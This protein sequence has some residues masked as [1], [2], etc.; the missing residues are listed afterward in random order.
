VVTP[1]YGK[2]MAGYKRE[3]RDLVHRL[4]NQVSAIFSY[5]SIEAEIHVK[6]E[7]PL[8]AEKVAVLIAVNKAIKLLE[9][10]RAV[11]L[12]MEDDE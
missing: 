1:D 2:A 9:K 6:D 11:I 8:K 7:I 5:F 4:T 10:L 12:L 3:L